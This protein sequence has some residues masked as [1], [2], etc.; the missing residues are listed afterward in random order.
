MNKS[1]L[2]VGYVVKFRNGELNMVMPTAHNLTLIKGSLHIEISNYKD[3]LTTCLKDFDIMEVYGYSKHSYLA[4]KLTEE[5]LDDRKLLWKREP[6]PKIMTLEEVEKELGC[7]IKSTGKTAF[8]KPKWN[9]PFN[10]PSD[11]R[12]VIVKMKEEEVCYTGY[13]SFIETWHVWINEED[14]EFEKDSFDSIYGW[15]DEP[16]GLNN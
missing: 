13:Y 3:D 5:A 4:L 7:K 10:P 14:M 16:N 1:D 15:I 12:N 2:K 11:R 9:S 8:N 6:D